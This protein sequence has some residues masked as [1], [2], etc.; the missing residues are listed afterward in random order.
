MTGELLDIDMNNGLRQGDVLLLQPY[1]ICVPVQV[2]NNGFPQIENVE[3]VGNRL[4]Y[5]LDQQLYQRSKSGAEK[6]DITE[7]QF[8]GFISHTILTT[9]L[10]FSLVG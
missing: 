8:A 2:L 3:G 9:V 5:K 7:Y 6:F 1:L 4:L 10:R